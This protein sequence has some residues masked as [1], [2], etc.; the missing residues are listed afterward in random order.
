MS[1]QFS[2]PAHWFRHAEESKA[3][4]RENGI[5]PVTQPKAPYWETKSLDELTQKEWESLCDG[6]GRC[7]LVKLEDEDTG[8]VHFTDIACRLFDG[9]SCHCSDYPR[10]RRRV[11]DCLKLTPGLVRTLDW[12]P[13]TCAYRLRAQG[14]PLAWWHPLVS[15]SAET[16]HQAGISVRGRIAAFETDLAFDDYPD[17]IVA[18]PGKSPRPAKPAKGQRAKTKSAKTKSAGTKPAKANTARTNSVKTK[19]KRNRPK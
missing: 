10:R 12:L 18:W 4:R 15:G 17:H 14:R 7:C 6:C 1:G 3:A 5:Q 2:N 19:P 9:K 11:K 13:P 8:K 16:V